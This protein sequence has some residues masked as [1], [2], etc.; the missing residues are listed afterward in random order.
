LV[1]VS[2]HELGVNARDRIGKGP[3]QNA[4]RMI[5]A[6]NLDELRMPTTSTSR[7]H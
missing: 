7:L 6:N 4:K 2:E 1:R 5:V 3:W